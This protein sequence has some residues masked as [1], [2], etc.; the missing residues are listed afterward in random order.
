MAITTRSGKG[1]ALTHSEMDTNLN[2]IPNGVNSSISDN[3]TNVG[4]GTSSP[5]QALHVSNNNDATNQG[6]DTCQL[7]IQ[8]NSSTTGAGA[9]INFGVSTGGE[10]TGAKIA[11]IRTGSNSVGDLAFYTR[12]NTAP[13]DDLTE[14]RVRILS[15]GG[16][17]FNGDTS[18][19][20]AL[21]D[22]EEGTWTPILY[23]ES[24]VAFS[25]HID[26]G[27]YIKIGSQVY[28]TARLFD[29]TTTTDTTRV[30]IFG[31]PFAGGDSKNQASSNVTYSSQ[32][33]SAVKVDMVDRAN[34]LSV[35]DTHDTFYNVKCNE[36]GAGLRLYF[37]MTYTTN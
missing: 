3:G 10:Y 36:I 17:T 14:E 1:S 2:Q 28:I 35:S 37:S 4:I 20:N 23:T 26:A 30:R 15:S 7:K 19:A 31:L 9:G 32:A 25:T 6:D 12:S 13:G 16:I 8:H 34:F 33:G 18:T 11:H 27:R 5:N 22:Y 29:A 21:D 24:G